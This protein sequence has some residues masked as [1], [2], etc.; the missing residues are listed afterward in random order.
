MA[1]KRNKVKAQYKRRQANTMSCPICNSTAVLVDIPK[2][3][4]DM[5]MIQPGPKFVCTGKFIYKSRTDALQFAHCYG[6]PIGFAIKSRENGFS[7]QDIL[8]IAQKYDEAYINSV[9]RKDMF[10]QNLPYKIIKVTE[11]VISVRPTKEDEI[12]DPKAFLN[13]DD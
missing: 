12:T 11:K 9:Y 8:D 5:M 2:D 3:I 13:E 4:A 10:F 1:H 6:V 7:E